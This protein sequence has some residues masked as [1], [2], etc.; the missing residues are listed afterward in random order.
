MRTAR[1]SF[2]AFCLFT[3]LSITGSTQERPLYDPEADATADI[4]NAV[5]K[6]KR[7]GKHV[8]LQIG[9]N[10]CPWC[11]RLHEYYTSNQE[12]KDLMDAHYVTVL[13]NY[14]KENRNID[15]LHDLGFPQRFGFPVLVVLD[16][17]GN[18]LHTQDTGLLESG[19]T[20]DQK[21]LMSFFRN[22]TPQAINPDS[23]KQ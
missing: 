4:E 10:W 16:P 1:I 21:K 14:S 9:G 8:L 18:R 2:L 15:V 19:G 6:A 22:W 5:S 13:V 12:I 7:E 23:Y 11:I 20:Y 17:Q 3:F